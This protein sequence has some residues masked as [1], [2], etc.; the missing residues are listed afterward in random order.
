MANPLLET[1]LLIPP[2]RTH[3]QWVLRPRLVE[4]LEE[5]LARGCRLTL[6]SAPAGFG[7]TT[8]VTGWLAESGRPAAW[9]SLDKGDGDPARFLSY[10]IAA[11][12]R[13]D[14]AIGHAAQTMS[15]AP[16]PPP[17]EAL[18]TALL[19]DVA[20]TPQPFVLVLDDLH[21][22]HDARPASTQIHQQ[23]AFLLDHLPL[24]PTGGIHTVIVTRKDPLL[25][26]ARWRA[27]GE[28]VEIRQA[29]LQFTA[30]EAADFLL[31]VMRLDLSPADVA[32][33]HR[34]TEGWI[35]GLQLAALAL[36]GTA[37]QGDL[38]LPG[39]ALQGTALPGAS[40]QGRDDLHPLVESF[41][42]SQRY[43]LDYL[44]EEVFQRQPAKTQRFLLHT[45]ILDRFSA[46][47]CNAITEREDSREVLLALEQGNQFIVPLDQSRRWYR[48]HH[49]FADLLRHRLR[50]VET[51]D[52]VAALHSRASRWYEVEG[53]VEDAIR[54]AL[55]SPD[56]DRAAALVLDAGESMLAQGKVTT[57]LGWCQ[58][59]PEAEIRARPKLCLSYS[60]ALILT[61]QIDAAETRLAAAE[62]RLAGAEQAAQD[63]PA[64]LGEV[65]AAQAYI[66][67]ARG[68]VPRTIELSRRALSL[69]SPEALSARSVVAL[70]L[71]YALWNSGRLAEAEQALA[72]AERAARQSGN[73]YAEL[74]AIFCLATI[75]GA[76]GR[77]HQ[78]EE[79]L[80]YAI[81]MG[82]PS[83][84]VAYANV[85]LA[86]LLYEWNDL[87]AAADH[88]RRGIDLGVRSANAEVQIGGYRALARI[89][90]AL[91]NASAALDAL[92]HLDRLTHE[93]DFPS[94]VRARNA[95]CHVQIA[96]AQDDRAAALRWAE[97]VTEAADAS[98]FYSL[99]DLTPAR[100]LLAQDQKA[101]AA[102]RLDALYEAAGDGGWQYGV[103]EVRA[104]QALAAPASATALAFLSDA[105][106]L[107]RSEGYVRTFVDKG[108]PMA[109]LLRQAVSR[110][111]EPHY[112][113]QLLAA[114]RA[115]EAPPVAQS[116]I[117]V[118]PA[119][120]TDISTS[121]ILKPLSERERQVLRLVAAG[122]SN[123]EVAEALYLSVNTVKTHLQR[124]YGKLVVGGRT[125]AATKAQ[126]LDL[127]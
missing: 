126:E 55:A 97:Q 42:G 56:L 122:L 62:S 14:P 119:V 33:L 35:A 80:R 24:P 23:L 101:A 125:V 118:R 111:I 117:S 58:A 113:S 79:R 100:L 38:V 88:A 37:L 43:I 13:V 54:H 36:Q 124:I 84:A 8:L 95:A 94:L 114:F 52:L 112:A 104:L 4:R 89:E 27:R 69:L 68:D 108:P 103:I 7:K 47:L 48:Y 102:E 107:A 115:V 60:W 66:A 17:P 75:Q 22:I 31:R 105:L 50:R 11:L 109:A 83:P 82:G 40:R 46:P 57:L 29:D 9:L 70:S 86:V 110:G 25:P 123:R 26:L 63:R 59:L 53:L 10:L 81:Q 61:D 19:N 6:I 20:A 28:L 91:G 45:S 99:F 71:G 90:Q 16:R 78:A 98:V 30:Q 72:E 127:L 1:K 67:R 64:F 44:I 15:Q 18:L 106:A 12:Q 34:R 41:A 49:L 96:L 5:G 51:P 121:E 87:P 77:L 76:W 32:A 120:G 73:A 65:L 21:L 3:A 93:G 39:A 85:N 92:Q 2:A 116:R 74:M